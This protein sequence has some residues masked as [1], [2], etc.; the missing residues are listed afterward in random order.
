M[1]NPDLPRDQY[2]LCYV[3]GCFA[4]FT[5]ADITKQWGDDWNDAPYEHN[6]E[7]PYEFDERWPHDTHKGD[8]IKLAFEAELM[9]P[10]YDYLNSPYSV[11]DINA[12][13]VP[14][15]R[16]SSW[17]EGKIAIQAGTTIRDFFK[18]VK[19]VGG[20]VYAPSDV[21]PQTPQSIEEAQRADTEQSAPTE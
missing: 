20:I 18:L 5:S 21:L 4:Y 13:K 3:D 11:Q 8:I 10:C 6:A 16:S 14:W 7:E 19:E 12:G 1:F 17:S 15:L 9:P 2:Q